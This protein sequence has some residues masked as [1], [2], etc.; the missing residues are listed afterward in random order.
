LGLVVVETI[1]VFWHFEVR[2]VEEAVIFGIESF[3]LPVRE[4]P[5]DLI[6]ASFKLSAVDFRE[7]QNLEGRKGN[8]LKG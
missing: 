5:K 2:E 7:S 6:F 4:I 1:S 3:E 8:F